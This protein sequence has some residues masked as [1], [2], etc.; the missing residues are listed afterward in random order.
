MTR[1]EGRVGHHS[2]AGIRGQRRGGCTREVELGVE[3]DEVRTDEGR[4]GAS[5][6]NALTCA[7]R[8]SRGALG[9]DRRLDHAPQE[10]RVGRHGGGS[11]VCRHGRLGPQTYTEEPSLI[12]LS[13][14]PSCHIQVSYSSIGEAHEAKASPIRILFL[15]QS[16]SYSVGRSLWRGA[17][18]NS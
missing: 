4:E 2:R 11:K 7:G 15:K 3:I 5:S 6:L 17:R 1:D 18:S 12:P 13:S 16:Y 8:P 10:L 9:G 14:V